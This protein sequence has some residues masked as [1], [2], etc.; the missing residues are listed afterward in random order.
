LCFE[1][2]APHHQYFYHEISEP[3]T[4]ALKDFRFDAVI[5]D[6]SASSFRTR[7]PH[8]KFLADKE[9]YSFIADWD[10]VKVAFPQDEYDRSAFLDDW[11]ADY[12][13]DMI[14]SNLCQ[15][16]AMLYPRMSK[17][18]RILPALTGYVND[19]DIEALGA[20]AKPFAER[21]VDIG[22]RAR[23]LP[24]RFGR[25][26]QM[27]GF[28]AGR[29][30]EAVK[31]RDLVTDISTDADRVFLGD[32][33]QRFLGD[34]RF[35]LGSET[36]SSLWDPEGKIAK[37][38]TKFTRANPNASF[39]EVEASC[40]PGVDCRWDF[41]AVSPRIFEAAVMGCGQILVEGNYLEEMEP[42]RHYL[43][44]DEH[45]DTAPEILSRMKDSAEMERMIGDCHDVLIANPRYRYSTHV[46]EVMDQITDLV[47]KKR[48]QGASPEEFESMI[49]R[50]RKMLPDEQRR[51]RS[52]AA[53]AKR[54]VAKWRWRIQSMLPAK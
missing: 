28:L 12:H 48:V 4:S 41:S 31:G 1:R 9:R 26:G 50:H 14:Y 13:F 49:E 23:F 30:L 8:Y 19:T 36:G 10:A 25:H 38:T 53:R 35:C 40:F 16:S 22:Y 52:R 44:I 17:Q 6:T 21:R 54:S 24:A 29:M 42:W 3:P 15:H 11:L 7:S 51:A 18:A 20:F 27:K 47:A 43:P 46:T 33:W 34:C 2:Y 5:F 32:D 45:C 37:R 39:E